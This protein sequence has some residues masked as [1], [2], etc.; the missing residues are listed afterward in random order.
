M[1]AACTHTHMRIRTATPDARPGEHTWYVCEE[2]LFMLARW[3]C[4]LWRQR[5]SR[6]CGEGASAL[7]RW[8]QKWVK[9]QKLPRWLLG[10]HSGDTGLSTV[11]V[12]PETQGNLLV[13]TPCKIRIKSKLHT[14]NI[15]R[16]WHRT[17]PFQKEEWDILRKYWTKARLKLSKA[18]SKSYRSI[19][20]T[21]GLRW[22]SPSSF[23]DCII[24]LSL[25]LVS[26]Q[27]CS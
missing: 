16:T 10:S 4:T 1:Q 11:E 23:A 26:L 9:E 20:H 14:S 21:K 7:K 25:G 6:S 13:V 27:V 22:L 3:G 8:E 15:C 18:N 12:F 17:L 2:I 5:L 24:I 19:S